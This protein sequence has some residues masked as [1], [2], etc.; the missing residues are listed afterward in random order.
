MG[1]SVIKEAL[2]LIKFINVSEINF[3]WEQERYIVVLKEKIAVIRRNSVRGADC[4]IKVIISSHVSNLTIHVCLSV[5]AILSHFFEH[6]QC[7]TL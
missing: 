7:L 4:S 5:S 6:S 1:R 3:R 2:M